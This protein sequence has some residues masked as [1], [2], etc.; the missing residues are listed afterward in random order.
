MTRVLQAL[1]EM[2]QTAAH[3]LLLARRIPRRFWLN[4]LF[5]GAISRRVFFS[6]RGR[7]APGS[8]TRCSGRSAKELSSSCRPRWMVFS[9]SPVICASKR[10]PPV[11]MRLDS[12]AT[13]QRRC[14]SSSRRE[15]QIHLP[16]QLLIRMRCVLLA[17]RT[18]TVMHLCSRHSWFPSSV[19][20][21]LA[22]S[23]SS[24]LVSPA[25]RLERKL[26]FNEY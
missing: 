9:S 8:R 26:F 16:M 4:Q 14:C 6:A 23:T 10:S 18:L 25:Q 13:Y 1:G 3:P 12:T 24:L 2:S 22:Y 5:Q 7:P 17:M 15:P 21:L 20:F 11:P 19:V